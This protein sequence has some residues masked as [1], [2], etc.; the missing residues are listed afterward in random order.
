MFRFIGQ[1]GIAVGD[2]PLEDNADHSP[3]AST[4]VL[5]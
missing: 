2:E 1:F 4:R 3:G 5:R